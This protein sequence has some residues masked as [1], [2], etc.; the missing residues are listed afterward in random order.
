[1]VPSVTLPDLF[2]HITPPFPHLLFGYLM[3]PRL[4]TSLMRAVALLWE[5]CRG[6]VSEVF[7]EPS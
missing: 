5:K 3:S 4:T 2:G 7:Y 6:A 1:M